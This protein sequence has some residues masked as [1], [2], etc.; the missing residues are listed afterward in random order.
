M[1]VL[2][3]ALLVAPAARS[4]SSDLVVSQVF[5]GGGNS[6]AAY[7]NDFVELFNRGA[8]SVDVS[9]WT[10]QYASASSTSWQTT[11][12]SGSIAPGRYYLVQ[13]A[14][15]GANGS[16]LPAADASGTSNLAVSGGKVAL[17]RG[18]DALTCGATAG[19]CSSSSAVAD[20]IGYGSATDFEGSA[21]FAALSSTTA[22]LR[23]NGGCADT[24]ANAADFSA[25]APAPR[26]SAT[27]A[28]PCAGGPPPPPPPPPNGVSQSASVDVDIQPALSIALER[29]SISFANAHSGE[30]P[31]AI[32]EKVTVVSNNATGY[33]L[34]VHRAAFQPSDLPLGLSASGAPTGAQLGGSLAGGVVAPIPI[35]PATDL[36]IGTAAGKSGGAGDVWPTS[37]GFA[38]AL[39]VVG[40]GK[41]TSSVTFT[42]I[43]R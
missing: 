13:L 28:A 18:A 5:A 41:Y 39:P 9:G 32:S 31:S 34:S 12:L 6:G 33:A 37:V 1:L 10:I 17:V 23:G 40:A 36:L 3:A 8:S 25:V 27:A 15:G 35:A 22:A 30:T 20:L 29:S 19:S 16:A 24:D 26:N 2:T 21:A 43:A 4:A 14:S 38:S 42:V 7:A 11:A